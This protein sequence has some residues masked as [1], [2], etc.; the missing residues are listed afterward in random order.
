MQGQVGQD[1]LNHTQ[2]FG[3]DGVSRVELKNFSIECSV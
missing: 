3:L 1:L 2:E